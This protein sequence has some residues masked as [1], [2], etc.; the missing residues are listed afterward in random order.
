[1]KMRLL[2]STLIIAAIGVGEIVA[3]GGCCSAW[4]FA[5]SGSV[6]TRVSKSLLELSRLLIPASLLVRCSFR[7]CQRGK[8]SISFGQVRPHPCCYLLESNN[9]QDSSLVMG[10]LYSKMSLETNSNL[11]S[12]LLLRGMDLTILREFRQMMLDSQH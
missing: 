10:T 2:L 11:E 5:P 6:M 7:L 8:V 1:M 3:Q 12:G 9:V 4:W